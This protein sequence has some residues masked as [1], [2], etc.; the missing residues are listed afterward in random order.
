MR[1]RATGKIMMRSQ[2]TPTTIHISLSELIDLLQE[3]LDAMSGRRTSRLS[4]EAAR[5]DVAL[6]EEEV[7]SA[8]ELFQKGFAASSTV[9]RAKNKLAHARAA[10]DRLDSQTGA[11][12]AKY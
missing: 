8:E 10:A 12:G 11:G 4:A 7:R 1:D 2:F 3:K 6:A 5:S 9:D